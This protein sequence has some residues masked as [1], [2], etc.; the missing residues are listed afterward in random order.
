M[1]SHNF[2]FVVCPTNVPG[3]SAITAQTILCE[4]GADVSRFRN[5]SVLHLGWDAGNYFRIAPDSDLFA[6]SPASVQSAV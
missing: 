3:I 1:R 4:I 6:G 2:R 5:A